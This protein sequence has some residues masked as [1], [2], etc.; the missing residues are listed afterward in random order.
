MREAQRRAVVHRRR[1]G[2]ERAGEFHRGEAAVQ[3]RAARML[4]QEAL[5]DH[6][7]LALLYEDTGVGCGPRVERNGVPRRIEREGLAVDVQ[8]PV[9]VLRPVARD[10]LV[11]CQV[12]LRRKLGVHAQDESVVLAVHA[13]SARTHYH[14]RDVDV[15][16]SV[17]CDVLVEAVRLYGADVG[18]VVVAEVAGGVHAANGDVARGDKVSAIQPEHELA[19]HI[20]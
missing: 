11:D 2:A 15:D 3:D 12:V 6:L 5:H 16:V 18:R 17:T 9:T 1:A 20:D 4:L 8:T 7:A 14:V 10:W 19:R 13:E